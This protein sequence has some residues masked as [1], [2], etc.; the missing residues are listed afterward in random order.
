MTPNA[1]AANK[2]RNSTCAWITGTAPIVR[3]AQHVVLIAT[4]SHC[5]IAQYTITTITP[6]TSAS[7][8]GPNTAS[9]SCSAYATTRP[10]S[11]PRTQADN[12]SNFNFSVPQNSVNRK[13]TQ[14]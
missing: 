5:M 1:S 14:V 3:N 4:A 7:P 13:A 12:L 10:V 9:N 11:A 8:A 6:I 2:P